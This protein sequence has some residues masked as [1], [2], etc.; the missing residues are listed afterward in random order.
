M[1]VVY[2]RLRAIANSFYRG[3]TRDPTVGATALVHETY[4]RL[5]Q[6]NRLELNDREHF[7]SLAAQVMRR[8]LV[9]HARARR[10]EKRGGAVQHV[11]LHDEIPWVSLEGDD[12]FALLQALDE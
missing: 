6:Q 12:V 4:L 5:L 8:I 11:P 3:E 1:P 9:D 10:A 7:Y 2:P